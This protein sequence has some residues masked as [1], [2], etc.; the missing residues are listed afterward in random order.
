MSWGR[1]CFWQGYFMP[2]TCVRGK[3]G[4]VRSSSGPKSYLDQDQKTGE[5]NKGQVEPQQLQ[6]G[7]GK[8][9]FLSAFLHRCN[10]GQGKQQHSPHQYAIILYCLGVPLASEAK[11]M[12]P[13]PARAA[14]TTHQEARLPFQTSR[15]SYK[16]VKPLIFQKLAFAYICDTGNTSWFQGLN[17][18]GKLKTCLIINNMINGKSLRVSCS[19][20]NMA[21]ERKRSLES[22][23]NPYTR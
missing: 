8:T 13:N 11:V 3:G 18:I 12:L 14:D 16:E 4:C 2:R 1:K 7:Q 23:M 10:N 15:L 21:T 6:Q 22:N 20:Q 5:K 17:Y 19:E 9:A